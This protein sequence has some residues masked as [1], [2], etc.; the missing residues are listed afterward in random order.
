MDYPEGSENQHPGGELMYPDI[1][2]T[3]Q[4]PWQI[5]HPR[6]HEFVMEGV[7]DPRLYGGTVSDADPGPVE[8]DMDDSAFDTAALGSLSISQRRLLQERMNVSDPSSESD[9]GPSEEGE[10]RSV[11]EFSLLQLRYAGKEV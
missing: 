7:I 6:S 2:E 11:T 8:D 10:T 5:A 3:T 1:D 9:Y 4:Y